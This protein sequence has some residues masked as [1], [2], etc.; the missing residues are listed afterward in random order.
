M[1]TNNGD[2]A[3]IRKNIDDAMEQYKK[4]EKYGEQRITVRLP[5]KFK[6]A[7]VVIKAQ[8]PAA[9]RSIFFKS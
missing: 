5:H 2:K 7:T 6:R 4:M 1:K 8:K 3:K 9:Y